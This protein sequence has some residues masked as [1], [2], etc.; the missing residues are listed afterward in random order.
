[1]RNDGFTLIEMIVY[2]GLFSMI[3]GGAI[4][5]A[6]NIFE[7]TNRNQTKAMVAE[8]GI[9]LIGKINWALTGATAVSI[10][11][12]N[13]LSVTKSGISP[14]DN[15]LVFD[16]SGGEM[17]LNRGANSP[18]VLN[19]TNITISNLVFTHTVS[20]GDGIAIE[21]VSASFTINVKTPEGLQFSEDFHTI[22]Y[23]R[24]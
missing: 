19:N 7:S 20:S 5:S 14:S 21:S 23:I 4:V 12:S 16:S 22:K 15:P 11:S 13:K 18:Q 9:F 17:R 2:I 6:Y 10:P 8:E 24:K 1:M 3:I